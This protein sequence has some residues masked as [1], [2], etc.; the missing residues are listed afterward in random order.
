MWVLAPIKRINV[1]CIKRVELLQQSFRDKYWTIS[2]Q[3]L[4]D[5]LLCLYWERDKVYKENN[6]TS[7]Q[8]NPLAEEM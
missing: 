5:N 4:E 3:H 8:D 6:L 2:D 7:I 1:I